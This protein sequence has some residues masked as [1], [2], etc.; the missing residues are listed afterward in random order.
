[1]LAMP[2]TKP[3][4]AALFFRNLRRSESLGFIRFSC[5]ML[6]R[7]VTKAGAVVNGMV[8]EFHPQDLTR[9][10]KIKRGARQRGRPVFSS[11]A[12]ANFLIS[13]T[14]GCAYRRTTGKQRRK[15]LRKRQ[16]R[17]CASTRRR[18]LP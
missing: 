17:E 9:H 8:E 10:S 12:E 4:K 5:G 15:R 3:A 14:G 7:G 11:L 13:S 1:M 2:T 16:P 6:S 18:K